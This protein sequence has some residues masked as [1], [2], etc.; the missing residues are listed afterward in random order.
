MLSNSGLNGGGNDAVLDYVCMCFLPFKSLQYKYI[1]KQIGSTLI[2]FC[3]NSCS[4]GQRGGI[5]TKSKLIL[6]A[7]LEASESEG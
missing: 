1:D 6:L 3:K 5:V 7:S 4:S 2:Q